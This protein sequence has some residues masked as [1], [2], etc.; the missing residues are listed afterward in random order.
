MRRMVSCSPFTP[1]SR[2][3]AHEKAI[4]AESFWEPYIRTLPAEIPCGWAQSPYAWAETAIAIAS[5]FPKG[6]SESEIIRDLATARIAIDTQC[7]TIWEAWGDLLDVPSASD[8]R[9]GFGQAV[10]RCFGNDEECALAPYIDLCNHTV[11]GLRPTGSGDFYAVVPAVNGEPRGL[12]AG[13][14]L[15][16]SYSSKGRVEG[17]ARRRHSSDASAA[18]DPERRGEVLT[19]VQRSRRCVQNY[20]S[21]GFVLPEDLEGAQP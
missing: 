9:W 19:D 13:E 11:D 21:F 7:K 1:H 12:R 18:E 6:L 5:A 10:S 15:Y 17:A 20:L 16:I 3:Q 4:G 2:T 8:L 14:E